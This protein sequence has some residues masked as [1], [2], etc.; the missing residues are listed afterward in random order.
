MAATL[1]SVCPRA[2]VAT[3]IVYHHQYDCVR[4]TGTWNPVRR[5]ECLEKAPHKSNPLKVIIINIIIVVVYVL[6]CVCCFFLINWQRII[7]N[8]FYNT[9]CIIIIIINQKLSYSI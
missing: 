3:I 9:L 4:I 2:A 8:Y 1:P 7:Y 6:R 5:F